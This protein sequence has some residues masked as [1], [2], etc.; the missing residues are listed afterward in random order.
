MSTSTEPRFERTVRLGDALG[1]FAQVPATC[2][3]CGAK[4]VAFKSVVSIALCDTCDAKEVANRRKTLAA[5]GKAYR[6][7]SWVERRMPLQDTVIDKLPA[8]PLRVAKVLGWK[9]GGR[10]LVVHGS[11]GLGKSRTVLT[12]LHRLYVDDGHEFEFCRVPQ[13]ARE[14]ETGTFASQRSMVTRLFH[15]PLLVLDDVGK[16]RPTERGI[17]ALFDVIDTRTNHGLP[18]LITSN[19]N[20]EKLLERLSERDA[21]TAAAILRRVREFCV[22]VAF[23]PRKEATP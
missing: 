13:W 17:S 7:K 8:D 10:G 15:V 18:L 11:T 3:I 20:G 9:Y 2:R 22:N 21:E 12:L 16:E 4:T 1:D 6:A 5:E 14:L 23:V 19:Y